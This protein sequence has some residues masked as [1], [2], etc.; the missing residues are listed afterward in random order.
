MAASPWQ[1]VPMPPRISELPRNTAGRPVPGNVPWYG[2]DAGDGQ[3]RVARSAELGP[4]VACPCTPGQGAPAFGDQ[5]PEHQRSLMA[6]RRCGTCTAPI[7]PNRRLVFVGAAE[8]SYFLEPPVHPACAV[9]AL[10]VCPVLSRDSSKVSVSVARSFTMTERRITGL[11][12]DFR[13]KYTVFPLGS[14]LAKEAGALDMYV[15]FPKEA[16]QMLASDWLAQQP[17]IA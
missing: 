8:A 5:C 9:Y 12:H 2:T 11:G 4:Y 3:M 16:E 1:H 15:A 6:G 7:E 10:Q 14:A 13:P 17:S